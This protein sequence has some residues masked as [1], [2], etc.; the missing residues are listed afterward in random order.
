[1]PDKSD[2][3]VYLRTEKERVAMEITE[4]SPLGFGNPNAK[5]SLT[6]CMKDPLQAELIE[7]AG[8]LIKSG[9]LFVPVDKE[10]DGC[11]DGRIA[12]LVVLIK[13]LELHEEIIPIEN[14]GHERAKV[15]GGGYITALAMYIAAKF[16]TGSVEADLEA[17]TELLTNE[18]VYCGAH[19]GEHSTPEGHTTDCGA[20]DRLDEILR[21]AVTYSAEIRG[22]AEALIGVAGL[23]IADG[24]IEGA[25]QNWQLAAENEAYFE[26]SNGESRF[27]V[28]KAGIA[29]AQ[30]RS[31]SEKP[32]AV[33][34]DL[35]GSHK[36]AFIVV[37]YKQGETLSQR[38]LQD[39]LQKEYPDVD[40]LELPQAFVVD[41]WRIVELASA[42]VE[43]DA[44]AKAEATPEAQA[45][46]AVITLESAIYSGVAYQ[47]A[48]AATLTDGTLR[49]LIAK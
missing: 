9:E 29:D 4:I 36:E 12:N 28:I 25:Q 7:R 42:L 35:A 40:P 16:N 5:I 19:T 26:S 21:S 30:V 32:V 37:N 46:W 17:V 43:A 39:A 11:I 33:S 18:G 14:Q 20:N 10:D 15:A 22:T 45:T 41:A 8:E 23:K 44:K 31:G 48:T 47:L 3:D 38:K 1:M 27:T 49:N 2:S 24:V 13:D 34:K 6:E